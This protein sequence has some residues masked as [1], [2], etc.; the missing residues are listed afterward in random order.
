MSVDMYCANLSQRCVRDWTTAQQ[1]G[2][3]CTTD[4]GTANHE[5]VYIQQDC[6]GFNFVYLVGLDNGIYYY[7]D[8][9]SGLLVGVGSSGGTSDG[10]FCIA[11]TGPQQPPG[12]QCGDAGAT[13]VCGPIN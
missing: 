6:D 12:V 4:G 1:L 11:G 3:W 10:K 13:R 8:P 7:Y 2:T 5:S 9:H